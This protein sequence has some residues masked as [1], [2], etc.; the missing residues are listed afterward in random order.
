MAVDARHQSSVSGA[1][2]LQM[3]EIFAWSGALAVTGIALACS[4]ASSA[5]SD[6]TAVLRQAAQAMAGLHSVSA[7]VR[8][9]PGITVEGLALSSA[10]SKIQLPRDS[11]S[12][13]KVKQGDF[14]LDLRVVTTGGHVYVKLPLAGFTDLTSEQAKEFPD[15][16]SLFDP[17]S[18]LPAV[19][20]AGKD[21]RSLGTEPVA[22]V[23]CNKVG[24]I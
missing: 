8:F 20:P 21:I 17:H 15:V 11:D 19:L 22:G 6:P 23:G 7:D 2:L 5:P 16:S 10:T 18:G 12:T 4:N 9:G 24:K 3:R 14:L 13:F 1:S